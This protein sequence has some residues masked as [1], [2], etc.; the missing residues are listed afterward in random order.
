MQFRYYIT[1]DKIDEQK[2]GVKV[3]NVVTNDR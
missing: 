3:F 2:Y 1:K